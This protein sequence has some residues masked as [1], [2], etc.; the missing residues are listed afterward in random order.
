MMHLLLKVKIVGDN[1]AHSDAVI[2]SF[3]LEN[4]WKSLNSLLRYLYGT[5]DHIYYYDPQE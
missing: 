1:G 3:D 5:L 2:S 4:A